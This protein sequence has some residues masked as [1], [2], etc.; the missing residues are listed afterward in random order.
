VGVPQL[1]VT[2]L[3]GTSPP[4]EVPRAGIA[5]S[6]E[7]EVPRAGIGCLLKDF[8]LQSTASFAEVLVH[9]VLVACQFDFFLCVCRFEFA[10]QF[11]FVLVACQF[12]LVDFEFVLCDLWFG[13]VV[14]G[15]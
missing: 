2:C 8:E 12:V 3:W 13:T 7:A 1:A 11:E 15:Y 10:C 5:E 6:V 4:A 14:L 9:V